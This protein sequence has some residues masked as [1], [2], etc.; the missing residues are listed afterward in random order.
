ML[1]FVAG[2]LLLVAELIWQRYIWMSLGMGALV[3][4]ISLE[5]IQRAEWQVLIMLISGIIV[6]LVM[7]YIDSKWIVRKER[8]VPS[9]TSSTEGR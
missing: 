4:G 7:R 2:L 6:F 8:P 9:E 3:A 1:W 5:Y